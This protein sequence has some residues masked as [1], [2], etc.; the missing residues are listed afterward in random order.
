M[1][2]STILV[3]DDSPTDRH[4]L[5]RMLTKSGYQV[6]TAESGE[7]AM[8]KIRQH[9]PDLILMDVVMP[10]I[11]GFQATR[12]L[13]RDDETR[14][15]PIILCTSKNQET[16]K[17]WGLRQGARAYI[18]KPVKIEDLLQKINSLDFA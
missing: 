6:G 3:I 15:I 4:I 8:T 2:I 7:E 12:M 9:L 5:S 13:A 14:R 17:I 18:T 1:T 10:G 11:N 16:D